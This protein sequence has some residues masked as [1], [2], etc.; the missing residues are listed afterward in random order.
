MEAIEIVVYITIALIAGFLIL[1][2]LKGTDFGDFKDGLFG[3][4]KLEF[5]SVDESQFVANAMVFWE[6]CGLGETNSTLR[7]HIKSTGILNKTGFFDY[8]KQVNYCST[9]QSAEEE[10]GHA[11][12]VD[13]QDLVLPKIVT[14]A[15]NSSNQMLV[16]R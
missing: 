2:F 9:L 3:E 7:L 12:N 11:E 15:C 13:M 5:R 16:I 4:E 6:S 8:V 10:C 14:L 1:T